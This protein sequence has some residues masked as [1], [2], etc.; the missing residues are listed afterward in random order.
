[1]KDGDEKVD[2]SDFQPAGQD[3]R[4]KRAAYS[5]LSRANEALSGY[6]LVLQK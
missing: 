3:R 4:E 6:L 5:L 1:M 2:L